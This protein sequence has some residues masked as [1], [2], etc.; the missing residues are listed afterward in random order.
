MNNMENEI[1]STNKTRIRKNLS[2][3]KFDKLTVISFAF[4]RKRNGKNVIHYLC[5][6]ECG[7]DKIIAAASLTKG[8][9]TSC[10]CLRLTMMSELGKLARTDGRLISAK[11]MWKNSYTDGCSFELFLKLSQLPC[12]YCNNPPSNKFNAYLNKRGLIKQQISQDWANQSWF[13]YSGLDR[14]DCNLQHT[15]DNIVP[16][17]KTCNYAKRSMSLDQFREW[18]KNLFNNLVTKRW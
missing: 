3:Q 13:I 11:Q 9:T 12:Y 10:G 18:V 16:C 6:C 7:N 15:E 5:R 17:C 8:L 14:V 2:G 1:I 4:S